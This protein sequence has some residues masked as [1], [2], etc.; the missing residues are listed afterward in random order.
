MK[1][2]LGDSLTTLKT[3]PDKC[4][5]TCVTSP[6]YWGLRNYGVDGQ[7]GLETTPEEYIA[8]MVVVFREV[9][10]VLKD[11]GTLWL[12]MGDCYAASQYGRGSGWAQPDNQYKN[13]PKQN[14]SVF[15]APR[16]KH[17]LK[18]KDLVGQP[19]RVAFGLQADGWYL[20]QDIIWHKP[21]AMPESVA[22]RCTKAHE[23]IFLLSK[24][25]QYYFDADAIREP[26]KSSSVSRAKYPVVKF[27]LEDAQGP[28]GKGIR[29]D[30]QRGTI[31][32]LGNKGAN[33]RSVW[34][35]SPKP[36]HGAHFATYPPELI[37][38]CILAGAPTQHTVLDPFMGSGTTGYVACMLERDFIGIEL[39]PDYMKLAQERIG[40]VDYAAFKPPQTIQT[41]TQQEKVA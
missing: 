7:L 28:F 11:D 37:R 1:L 21:S 31:V 30:E 5:Q 6:P 33:K 34:T 2:F 15:E 27:G 39:H 16:Y 26:Y 8:Q 38:P 29:G 19:W 25:A 18:N 9:R 22:D 40:A 36:Y 13:A 4:I 20:R 24:N 12:N 10:R 32:E 41:P 14:R 3:L 35:V 23:Y 17:S